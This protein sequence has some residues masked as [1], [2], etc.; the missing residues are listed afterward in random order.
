MSRRKSILLRSLL[1]AGSIAVLACIIT[2]LDNSLDAR[3]A[4]IARTRRLAGFVARHRS[5]LLVRFI[6]QHTGVD[7]FIYLLDEADKKER[8]LYEAGE[9]MS[10][11]IWV[12]NLLARPNEIHSRLFTNGHS[13]SW[14][15]SP[16]DTMTALVKP[17]EVPYWQSEFCEVTNRVLWGVLRQ[18]QGTSLEE[19]L[20]RLP[21]GSLVDLDT[22]YKWLNES[23]AAGWRV[24]VTIQSTRHGDRFIVA[25]R[26]PSP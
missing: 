3:L 16:D 20:C 17:A 6:A 4:S 19:P 8:A 25:S 10:L 2:S 12:P 7:P 21:D 23:I 1:L 24:G 13:A 9:L 26:K 11:T 5:S 22:C 15:L 14:A 18:F